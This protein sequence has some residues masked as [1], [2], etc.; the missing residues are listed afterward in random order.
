VTVRKAILVLVLVAASFLGGAFVNGP[1]LHW[2]ETHIL[3]SL[4]LHNEGEITSVD[5]KPAASSEMGLDESRVAKL[6]MELPKGPRAPVPSVLP[7][8]QLAQWDTAD[9]SPAFK[10]RSKSNKAT[11]DSQDLE[12]TSVA[13]SSTSKHPRAKIK[14]L[15]Q[16]KAPADPDVKQTTRASNPI[17]SNSQEYVDRSAQPDIL[18]TLAALLPSNSESAMPNIPPSSTPSL[19]GTSAKKILGDR[20]DNWAVIE[21][22]MQH[23]G[24]SRYTI[25]GQPGDRVVFS[26]LIPVAGRQAIAQRFEAEGDDMVQAAQA[27]LRRITLWRATQ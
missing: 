1:G 18:D 3:R 19:P 20:N 16:R 22:K 14:A 4:G 8:D 24:I 15:A 13:L 26:C 11:L 23:L 21:R 9:H 7:E 6:G 5:L 10:D 27:A 2:I 17:D 25:D 12:D